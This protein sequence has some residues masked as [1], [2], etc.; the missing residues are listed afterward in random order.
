M[1]QTEKWNEGLNFSIITCGLLVRKIGREL[2]NL[3]SWFQDMVSP[4]GLIFLKLYTKS[5]N[6]L[7]SLKVRKIN[8]VN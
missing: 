4:L 3:V 5:Q 2:I 1:M 8:Y 6:T 7:C